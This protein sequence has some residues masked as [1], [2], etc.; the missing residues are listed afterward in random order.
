MVGEFPSRQQKATNFIL[1]EVLLRAAGLIVPEPS[2]PPRP[3]LSGA[4]ECDMWNISKMQVEARGGFLLR[5][6]KNRLASSDYFV[7]ALA[8]EVAVRTSCDWI[9]GWQCV[10]IC[11]NGVGTEQGRETEC[12]STEQAAGCGGRYVREG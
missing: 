7:D 6:C 4:T 9:L 10:A 11:D 5:S 3:P 12:V 8:N 2:M 1:P